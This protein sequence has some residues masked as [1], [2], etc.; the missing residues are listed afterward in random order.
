MSNRYTR[1]AVQTPS[2]Y[3]KEIPIACKKYGPF[4]IKNW[5]TVLA[6]GERNTQPISFYVSLHQKVTEDEAGKNGIVCDEK[7]FGSDRYQ[8][9]HDGSGNSPSTDSTMTPEND[10]I[11]CTDIDSLENSI[12][13]VFNDI[14][15]KLKSKD[16]NFI[17][18]VSK[19]VQRYNQLREG[20]ETCTTIPRIASAL[21]TFATRHLNSYKTTTKK[22]LGK[23]IKV[24][25]TAVARRRPGIPRG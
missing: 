15:L 14:I 13:D 22:R 23:I 7:G 11:D 6:L 18:G 2:C 21:H 1:K 9:E 19:F 12:K 4:N 5:E 8:I 3:H 17:Q 25:S 16:E 24:Q 10:L 20:S